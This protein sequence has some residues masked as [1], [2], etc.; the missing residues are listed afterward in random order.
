MSSLDKKMLRDLWH[1]KGQAL[2]ICLVMA[3]GIATF[4]MSFCTQASLQL[5]L[6]T[7]YDRYRF[8][9]VFTQVK[10]APQSL[11]ARIEEIPGVAHVQTRIM[12]A[13]TLDV[14][15]LTEPAMGR[16][17]SVRPETGLSLNDLHLRSGRFPEP[18]RAGEVVVHEAF[19]L[20]HGLAPGSTLSA[21]LNGRKQVLTIVGIG[22][23]PE[24]V[25][26]IREGELL[27]DD[28]RFGVFWMGYDELAAA[29]DMQGAFNSVTA[30][31]MPGAVEEEVLMRLDRLTEAYGG[32]GAH[33]RADQLS[34][35]FVA[36]EL[37][38]LK[39]MAILPP[40]IFLS[41]TAFLLN[42]VLSRLI[43]IQ[44]EQI[45]A[46]RAFGYSGWEISGHYVKMVLVLV[47]VGAVLGSAAGIALG[48]D[49]TRLYSQFFRFPVFFFRFDPS[50]VILALVLSSGAALL[51]TWGAIRHASRLPP[52]EA[53]RPEPPGQFRPTVAERLGLQRFLTVGVRMILR[54]LERRPFRSLITI[55]GIAM[56]VAIL[57][58]GNFVIDSV[59]YVIDFQFFL[60]QRQDMMVTF[61][62]PTSGRVLHDVE[63]L[64]GV[65]YAEAYR[66]VP[67][68]LR[69]G[70]HV[71]KL[72]ILG[73]EPRPLL[74][75]LVDAE[76]EE[77]PL[78]AE[79]VILSAKLA[80]V[81][82]VKV[83]DSV[84]AEIL[85]GERPVRE[86]VV[87]GLVT[88]FTTLGAY[89]SLAALNRLM[90]E[91][92]TLSGVFVSADP[93]HID[94]LYRE[95]K[96]T[97]KVAAVNIKKAALESFKKTLDEHL[98]RMVMFNVIFASIIAFGVV[99]NSARI[100]LSERSRELATLRVIGFTR[101]EISSILLGELAIL[102]LAALPVGMV[103]GYGLAA[104]AIW[105]LETETQRFPLIVGSNTYAF[106]VLVIV[107]ASLISGLIVRR[108]L[109]RLDLVSVLKARE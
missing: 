17:I 58:L 25:Y 62:E 106:A 81:L 71:R 50:M 21:V 68:R 85:E 74:F 2:A 32:I 70:H 24:Y 61:V 43:S 47:V 26:T 102:T 41:V 60:S 16:L 20:S 29:F 63:H 40:A 101:G 93:K 44:R 79:G 11:A 38:Q 55:V 30:R 66:A 95:L 57:I 52:A 109:D 36:N 82:H 56:A 15:G 64:P 8:A 80:E 13:V 45:A 105:A 87:A 31:L 107:I 37:T 33:G 48:Y 51:G 59:D 94:E 84:S 104:L 4:V 65:I 108:R 49:M 89:M 39:S 28:R 99:Y 103:I 90:R 22:L 92:V 86:V 7:Y 12:A 78:P 88:D 98:L 54:Q 27:P 18:D 72:A 23:S 34:H 42:V 77:I 14:P 3:C 6:D 10:R 91:D 19:A 1:M 75:R 69:A 9:D 97:P 46:L 76:E 5:T 67:V 73:L 35:K 53:M 100:S 96:N 83:G